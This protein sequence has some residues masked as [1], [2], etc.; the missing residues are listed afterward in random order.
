[1]LKCAKCKR[2][3]YKLD[4]AKL[5]KSDTVHKG[6]CVECYESLEAYRKKR[7]MDMN[8]RT[9]KIKAEVN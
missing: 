3:T 7:G 9:I 2:G 4:S 5:R 8:M 1:M 6:I